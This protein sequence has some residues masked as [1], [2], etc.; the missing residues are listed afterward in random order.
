MEKYAQVVPRTEI[1][2][3]DWNLSISR[4]VD[5]SEEEK[6][7]DF[8]ETV[9]KLRELER[10]CAEVEVPINRYLAELGDGS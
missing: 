10:K 9:R 8:M 2:E 1:E 5:T 4:Y 3:N 7:V 6:R